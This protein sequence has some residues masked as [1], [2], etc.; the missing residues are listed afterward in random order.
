MIGQLG[1]GAGAVA[2][3]V[4]HYLAKLGETSRVAVRY[5]KRIV[6][7]ASFARLHPGDGTPADAVERHD[8]SRLAKRGYGVVLRAATFC[9]ARA[10]AGCSGTVSNRSF[11]C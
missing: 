9:T 5:E 4:F 8:F 10:R 11:K 3:L 1:Q 7:K 2:D 6:A